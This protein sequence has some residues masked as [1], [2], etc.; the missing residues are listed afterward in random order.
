MKNQGFG[1]NLR[2]GTRKVVDLDFISSVNRH[3]TNT[4]S[5]QMLTQPKIDAEPL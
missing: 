4:K 1:Y 2:H 3:V 5:F